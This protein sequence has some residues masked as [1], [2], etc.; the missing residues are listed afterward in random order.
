MASSTRLGQTSKVND[1]VS[2]SVLKAT[3]ANV[4]AKRQLKLKLV[5]KQT[6]TRG[7]HSS[8]PGDL[9]RGRHERASASERLGMH[10]TLHEATV[11]RRLLGRI[12]ESQ[13]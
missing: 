4:E 11:A 2:L 3:V 12:G 9:G 7:S 5:K 6:D 1:H 8:R 10:A 13:K